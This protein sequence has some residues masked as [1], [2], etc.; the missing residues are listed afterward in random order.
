MNEFGNFLYS[1]RKSAGMTQQELADKL[2]VTNKAISKWETGEAFPETAQ[3]VP[4]SD[5]FG[6]TVDALLRGRENAFSNKS[7]SEP[8]SPE[9]ERE[10]IVQKYAPPSWRKKFALLI[11]FGIVLIFAGVLILILLELLTDNEKTHL[12]GTGS[13]LIFIAAG[14]VL[15]IIAGI[16]NDNAFLPVADPLWRKN[17]NRFAALISSGVLAIIF[18]AACFTVV[19]VFEEKTAPFIAIIVLGFFILFSGVSLLVYGGVSWD[20][21]SKHIKADLKKNKRNKESEDALAAL[22]ADERKSSLG[23]RISGIIMLSATAIYLAIGFIW[24]L[25]H[26]SWVVFPIGGI[27]CGII[28]IIFEKKK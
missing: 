28:G 23:G 16:L 22:T 10:R 19:S 20:G 27:L 3:L 18:G 6:V 7:N 13:M 21:Y 11:C 25:W 12:L 24:N 15:F 4:L 8:E 2:G 1:L 14:V 17:I 26:P 5:I 9:K